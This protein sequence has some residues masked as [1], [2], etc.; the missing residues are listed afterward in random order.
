MSDQEGNLSPVRV[1]QVVTYMGRGGLETMLMNY[2]RHID[3]SQVQFD[4]LVHRDFTADYDQEILNLGGRIYRLPRLNPVSVQYQNALRTFFDKHREYQ[5]VHSHLDCMAGIP[6][7]E[8]K[9]HGVPVCI[10]HA[11]NNNQTKDKKYLL[12][13]LYKR[14]IPRVADFLFACSQEAGEWMFGTKSFWILNNAIDAPDYVYDERTRQKVRKELGI[15]EDTLLVGH[16][17]RF[18]PPKNHLMLIRIMAAL[19]NQ[20]RD[21][22][23]L[24]VGTGD[25]MDSV[26]AEVRSLGLEKNVIFA[27]LRADV[28][29]LVQAMDVFAFPSI[30]EGLPLSVIEA[31]AA[32][33]PCIISDGVPIECKKTDLVI[34]KKL[35]D[36]PDAWADQIMQLSG[37]PR[38]NTLDQITRAGFNVNVEAQKLQNFYL[39]CYADLDHKE[40]IHWQQ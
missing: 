6:L 12:K 11:H 8:A 2:Y 3:R 18:A 24:L 35:S 29:E 28:P 1:L 9:A 17:G 39:D 27:G 26:K 23:L 19:K 4:F 21:S 40:K 36:G 7:Q 22:K 13:L 30:H 33:L 37:R 20:C 10:A 15:S 38:Q 5:V 32:G 34:Q 14:K 31:Q 16:V 25:G